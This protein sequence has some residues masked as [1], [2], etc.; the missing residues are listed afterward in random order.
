MLDGISNM[1]RY[2]NPH[3]C[4]Q[5]NLAS[6]PT[7]AQSQELPLCNCS[8][9]TKGTG[10]SWPYAVKMLFGMYTPV[11]SFDAHLI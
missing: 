11:M 10:R 5:F 7:P 9:A 2:A 8:Q 6:M 1:E 3:I 4:R